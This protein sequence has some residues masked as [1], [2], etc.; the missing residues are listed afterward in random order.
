MEK[1]S[2]KE[3]SFR[4]GDWGPKYLINGPRWEGGFVVFHPGQKL[5]KHY[6][7]EV[8]ETFIFIEG[9][10]KIII[11]DVEYRAQP[12]DVFRIEPKESHDI[13]NDTQQ[14]TKALF[15]KCPYIPKDKVSL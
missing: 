11:N 6:H 2:E 1:T 9:S 8:E 14:T 7:N 4:F 15:I 3:K 12:G 10:P 5:G 13:I